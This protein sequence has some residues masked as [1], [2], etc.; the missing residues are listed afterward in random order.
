M[1][2]TGSA[3]KHTAVLKLQGTMRSDRHAKRNDLDLGGE[4][5]KVPAFLNSVAKAEW[6]RVCSI[7]KYSKALSPAD[8]GALTLYCIL[9]S[10][11]KESQELNAEG[12]LVP[13]QS[14]RMSVFMNLAGKFGMTPSDRAKIQMPEEPKVQNKFAALAQGPTAV[15]VQ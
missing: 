12:F 9:W 11:L 6:K 1:P 5:P 13:M 8:R 7:G 4:L 3:P 10:E 14:A 2:R 15:Q